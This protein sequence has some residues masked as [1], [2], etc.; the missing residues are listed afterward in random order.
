[1]S[2]SGTHTWDISIDYHQCPY[3]H[4]IHE[5]RKRYTYRMGSYYKDVT[6]LRCGH[7]F[8]LQKEKPRSFGPLI[9]EAQPIEGYQGD[10]ERYG[11]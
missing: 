1:M 11:K 6:C 3:C 8:T 7:S 2:K 9:G 5:D 10:P 4:Y